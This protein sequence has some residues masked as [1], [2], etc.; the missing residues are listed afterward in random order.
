MD[1]FITSLL[2]DP[3]FQCPSHKKTDEVGWISN[4]C[5][6]ILYPEKYHESEISKMLARVRDNKMDIHKFTAFSAN[7]TPVYEGDPQWCHPHCPELAVEGITNMTIP[8]RPADPTDRNQTKVAD[9]LDCG[10]II[11]VCHL[12]EVGDNYDFYIERGNRPYK[13]HMVLAEPSET[14]LL[15]SVVIWDADNDCWVLLT[16][17]EGSAESIPE[18]GCQAFE[19]GTP[20]Q[21]AEWAAYW[22]KMGLIPD[23]ETY[24]KAFN[25][26]LIPEDERKAKMEAMAD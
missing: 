22:K 9:T 25:A 2:K 1:K 16:N 10:R 21:Q 17:Y 23:D 14:T 6:R 19:L 13:S 3:R 4:L 26:G 18:P 5:T 12:V 15:A 7:G 8:E 11:G 24:W 20:E